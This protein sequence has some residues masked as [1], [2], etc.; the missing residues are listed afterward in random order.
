MAYFP[1]PK[2]RLTLDSLHGTTGTTMTVNERGACKYGRP[3]SKDSG[4]NQL[5]EVGIR[6]TAAALRSS[7]INTLFRR[8]S[9]EFP[10]NSSRPVALLSSFVRVR[11]CLTRL[12]RVLQDAG[13]FKRGYATM[14]KAVPQ[15]ATTSTPANTVTL[16]QMAADLAEQ[17]ELSRRQTEAVITDLMELTSKHLRKGAR[18]RLTGLGVLQVRKRAAR[19]GRNPATGETIKIRASKKV[20][21]RASKELKEAI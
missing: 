10:M 6:P 13:E 11:F 4:H 16:R 3:T 7:A 1:D 18:I 20:A 2:A 19:M 21:F 9:R 5:A 8:S 17:H 14:A 12:G 15:S